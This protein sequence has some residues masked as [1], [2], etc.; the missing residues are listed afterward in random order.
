MSIKQLFVALALFVGVSPVGPAALLAAEPSAA[1]ALPVIWIKSGAHLV[2]IPPPWSAVR[3]NETGQMWEADAPWPTVASHVKVA[4]FPPGNIQWA[5]D[6]DLKNAFSE[7]KRRNI[8]L[9]L[10]TGLLTRTD[11]CQA[12]NEATG[13]PGEFEQMLLKI[14]RNGGEV[15]YIAM[16]EPYFYGHRDP[17]GCHQSAAELAKN[18]AASVAAA[19]KIFPKIQIGDTEVVGASRPFIDELAAWADA[20]QAAVGEKLAFM[21][22]DIGWSELA[23]QNLKPLAQAMKARNIPLGV[24][25][26]AVDSAHTD[27]S[28]QQSAE[29]H[30]AEIETVLHIHPDIAIFDSWTPNPAHVLPETKPGP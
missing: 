18:V 4:L 15:S 3:T 9:A 23:I 7:M 17:S 11:G 22:T 1:P 30:I 13:A 25:Y 6:E 29:D 8:A 19:R 21:Q 10:G 12:K 24:I 27:E 20:Y 26:N 14:Q 28:W 16:D 2:N 5:K